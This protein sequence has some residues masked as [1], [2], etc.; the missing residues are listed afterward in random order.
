[1][2][3]GLDVGGAHI[4]AV[5]RDGRAAVIPFPLWREP[6]CLRDVLVAAAD[7]FRPFEQI[8]LTMTAELCDCFATKRHGVEAVLDAVVAFAKGRPVHVWV[9]PGGF[10]PVSVA[11]QCPLECAA[12]NWHALATYVA[13][14]DPEKRVLLIDTG[15]TT[16][17]V[18][19][20]QRGVVN[21][22]GWTDT[23]RLAMG[24][25][26][27][28]GAARTPLMAMGPSVRWRHRDHGVMAERFAA[29]ADVFVLTG[30]LDEASEDSDTCD[31]RP[32]TRAYAA[33]RLLRMIGADLEM[34]TQQD[35]VS[36]AQSFADIVDVRVVDAIHSV[37]GTSPVDHVVTSG[38]GAFIADRAS[39]RALPEVPRIRLADRIGEAT[40]RAAC[41]YALVQLLVDTVP[42]AASAM[43]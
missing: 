30:D 26:V 14:A 21:A 22:S 36:L 31:G 10:V 20:L 7:E 35:A 41:A 19:R 17:D 25:L 4:K 16:T 32:M 18:V 15:S 29:T 5:H 13:R 11:R 38:S 6:D 8:A 2:I 12:A 34:L 23:D 27:Y 37:V 3:L 9:V 28:V 42:D 39:C 24:E 33:A 40:S 43:G 1:M